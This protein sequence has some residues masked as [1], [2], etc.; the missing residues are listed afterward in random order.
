MVGRAAPRAP[1]RPILRESQLF[2]AVRRRARSDAPY[3]GIYEMASRASIR[4]WRRQAE[5]SF[6]G[7][8]NQPNRFMKILLL[9]LV[10]F[11][12]S[13]ALS[14]VAAEKPAKSNKLL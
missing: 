3:R 14:A 6:S 4:A 11:L 5:G 1:S 7:R 10:S 2:Q 13:V 12:S 9:L 8:D